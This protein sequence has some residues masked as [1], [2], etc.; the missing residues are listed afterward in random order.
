MQPRDPTW[1]PSSRRPS[2]NSRALDLLRTDLHIVSC[3]VRDSGSK[4]TRSFSK[5]EGCDA[6]PLGNREVD[7]IIVGDPVVETDGLQNRAANAPSSVSACFVSCF[8]SFALCAA[9]EPAG[10]A[11]SLFRVLL[12]EA[13][14]TGVRRP[15][16]AQPWVDAPNSLGRDMARRPGR[17]P[18]APLAI[19][20]SARTRR[21]ECRRADT[22]SRRCGAISA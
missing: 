6:N 8:C 22:N 4:F 12:L 5:W 17:E 3:R 14:P 21:S 2:H 9:R 19:C 1:R 15:A 11:R 18:K 20:R 10:F 13:S 7:L 16:I